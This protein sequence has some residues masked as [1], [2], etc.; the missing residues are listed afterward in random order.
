MDILEICQERLTVE[1]N[2]SACFKIPCISFF[3][4]I[5]SSLKIFVCTVIIDFK[6]LV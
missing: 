1:N 2:T 4:K 6:I 5:P 3:L